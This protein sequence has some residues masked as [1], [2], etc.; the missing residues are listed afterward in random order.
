MRTKLLLLA[1]LVAPAGVSG[2]DR[3][4]ETVNATIPVVVL[5]VDAVLARGTI[6]IERAGRHPASRCNR[7]EADSR[8]FEISTVGELRD[9]SA[10]DL[11]R[12]A[13]RL[14]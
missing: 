7:F 12:D 13:A 1:A 10:L 6:A 14:R 4:G 2:A 8:S 5:D 3:W 11:P 9:G